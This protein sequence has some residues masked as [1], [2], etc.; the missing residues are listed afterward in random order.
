MRRLVDA[1][2]RLIP[3]LPASAGRFLRVYMVATSALSLLD[4]AALGLLAAVLT[5]MVQGRPTTLPVVGEV[6]PAAYPWVLLAVCLLMVLKS[7]LALVIQWNAT[8]RFSD[9]ELTVGDALFDA[10]IRAPWTDRLARS[11]AEIVRLA[12]VGIA[13][14]VSGVLLPAISLPQL[15]VTFLAVLLVLVVAQPLTAV[16]TLAYLALVAALMYWGISRKAVEAGRVNLRYSLRISALMTE[17]VSALKEITLRD[18]F[19]AVADVVHETRSHSTRARAN[20]Q[21]LGTVPQ[22]VVEAAMVGGFVLVWGMA[23]LSGGAD[24]AWASVALFAVAGFRMVPSIVSFQGV[25]TTTAN[26]LPHLEA[27]LRDIAA[28]SRYRA[29]AEVVGSAPLAAD[30]RVLHL[31][32]VTFT[33]PGAPAPAVDSVEADIAMG[34]AVGIVGASGSGKSTLVDLVLGLLVPQ[35]GVITID[36]QPLTEVLG[37]WRRR[38]GYVPQEVA[39]FDATIAQ[40]IALTWGD[41]VDDERVDAVVAQAQLSHLVEDRP[42][43][44]H[45]RIGERGIALSGGERQRLGIARAL[46]ADP[47]VLVLDEATSALDT[48]TEDAIARAIRG[49][50][51][52]VTVISVAHRLSTIRHCDQVCF[53][54]QG[55]MV[56]RGT[57]DELVSR[58]PDFAIQAHLAG[59]A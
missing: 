5:P 57:F 13:N 2:G 53:M 46:Y 39:L 26:S 41:D 16:V 56:A 25:M 29:H 10:Y 8:R 7:A 44:I 55:R 14:T 51:G 28:A 20:I 21:F 22:R 35:R 27:V 58:E 40:N 24:R 30:P 42:G 15:I 31:H 50:H 49:L 17:M 36:D 47:L 38:V 54:R 43:G 1:L 33:Y 19:D 48:A 12:D 34:S 11:T 52:R 9:Y 6:G 37:A 23:Q 18:K 4:V 59:L 32:D 45:A 3:L